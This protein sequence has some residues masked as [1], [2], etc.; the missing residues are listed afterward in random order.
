MKNLDKL[1]VLMAKKP[2]LLD[3]ILTMK[4][5]IVMV[6]ELSGF[7]A[8]KIQAIQGKLKVLSDGIEPCVP[9]LIN[10]TNNLRDWQEWSTSFDDILTWETTLAILEDI[11]VFPFHTL[12]YSLFKE[13]IDLNK[14]FVEAKSVMNARWTKAMQDFQVV[15]ETEWPT[16]REIYVWEAMGEIKTLPIGGS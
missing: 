7:F 12:I 16:K 9:S 13:E 14:F 2:D 5:S 8:G 4:E 3:K 10:A 11:Y 6:K 1:I 15:K